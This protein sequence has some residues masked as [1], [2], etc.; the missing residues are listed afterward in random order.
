MSRIHGSYDVIVVGAGPGG[1]TAA[2]EL[3]RHGVK[4]ALLEQKRLPRYKPC[5][6]CLSLRIDAVLDM[7]FH[8]LVEKTVYGATFTFAGLDPI[9]VRS[10]RPVA[11]MVMR[12]RFD[13]ALARRAAEAGADLRDGERVQ[14]V[15]EGRDEVEVHTDAGT[16]RS[17]FLVAADG[18]NG[19]VARRLNMIP[20]RRLA[21]CVE[22]EATMRPGPEA[23]RS[24]EVIIEC[25]TVPFGYGW[26]FPKANHLSLG[27]GGLGKRIGNPR[28]YYRDFLIEQ[29]L[30]DEIVEEKRAGYVLPVFASAKAR[31]ASRR[32]ALV[33]DAAALVDPFLGEGIY[34]AIRS[35]Q[36]AG[37]AVRNCLANGGG[38]DRSGYAAD[39]AEEFYAEFRA[40]RNFAFMMYTF[41]RVAYEMLRR[42]RG[43]VEL[44]FD[45]LRGDSSYR[46]VWREARRHSA[47]L[48]L[49]LLR[50]RSIRPR[51]A[52]A[53]FDRLARDYDASGSLW[54]NLAAKPVWDALGAWI[55]ET[56]RSGASV[57]DAG[58][59]TGEA[60]RLVLERSDPESIIG[61]DIS[62]GMLHEA[63]RKIDDPRVRWEQGDI[64]RLPYPDDSFDLVLCTW[65][66][67]CVDDPVVAV[68]EFL[69]LIRPD[70]H[71]VYA[72]STLPERGPRRAIGRMIDA[73]A[74]GAVGGRS[75]EL[76]ETPYHECGRSRILSYAGG[77]STLV[78]LA[79]CCTVGEAVPG[80]SGRCE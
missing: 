18:A 76:H 14:D 66:L 38:L 9:R 12:D 33:G 78:V 39:L 6:G 37:A 3:A 70:G 58:T 57:L 29:E 34:Y 28:S 7:D 2:Y 13:H 31:R 52:E 27:V 10:D 59:G 16:L 77:L 30:I 69:R 42:H 68:R 32:T 44:Y 60:V 46:D 25:G 47:Q 53:Q 61:V 55:G 43:F 64:S 36:L 48:V 19:I 80:S 73:W 51:S 8:D 50:P 56:V 21:I 11:Y 67:E 79:K 4:V 49:E 45:L 22:S 23:W 63:R 54:R 20:K 62:R 15:V 24:D 17:S 41:P 75:V 35:G 65:G 71:V 40:A 5:G 1:S 74:R 72:L 26:V